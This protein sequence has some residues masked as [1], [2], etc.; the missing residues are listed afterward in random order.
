M[1]DANPVELYG[2]SLINTFANNETGTPATAHTRF[3]QVRLLKHNV[4]CADGVIVP[5]KIS[6][7][8]DGAD[9]PGRDLLDRL[10]MQPTLVTFAGTNFEPNTNDRRTFNWKIGAIDEFARVNVRFASDGRGVYSFGIGDVNMPLNSGII[11]ANPAGNLEHPRALGF[12]AILLAVT[13]FD[14]AEKQPQ[15]LAASG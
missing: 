15:A 3:S 12:A 13:Y 11:E 8:L 7:I 5:D 2:L 9:L 1:P 10:P 6:A 14:L 4:V